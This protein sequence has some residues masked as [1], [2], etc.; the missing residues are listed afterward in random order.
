[1]AL[2]TGSFG[3]M[4]PHFPLAKLIVGWVNISVAPSH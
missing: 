3:S 1:M 4:S 2:V